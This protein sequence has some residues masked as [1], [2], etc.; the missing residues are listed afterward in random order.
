MRILLILSITV[1]LATVLAMAAER[2]SGSTYSI[3]VPDGWVQIPP[4]LVTRMAE[5]SGDRTLKFHS[6]FSWKP[7]R[8]GSVALAAICYNF[9]MRITI[10]EA[11]R[12]FIEK[13]MAEAGFDDA[14]A[15]FLSLAETVHLKSRREEIDQ[16]LLE[17]LK[18][19][20][21]PMTKDDWEWVRREGK[22]R[23]A[24]RKSR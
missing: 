4:Y 8:R 23:L 9:I 11:K 22:R 19:P 24:R 5:T 17:A 10:P 14:G 6:A 15:Y 2:F 12:S 3:T 21:S 13:Q 20:S 16:L 7:T 1:L 18:E